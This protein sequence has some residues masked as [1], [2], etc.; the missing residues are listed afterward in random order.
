VRRKNKKG[1]SWKGNGRRGRKR[2]E[3]EV[4]GEG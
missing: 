1:E 3:G 4:E 2:R